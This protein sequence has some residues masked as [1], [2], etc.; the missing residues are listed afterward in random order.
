MTILFLDRSKGWNHKSWHTDEP[1][2]LSNAREPHDYRTCL[3]IE[4]LLRVFGALEP[5]I[6][7][8]ALTLRL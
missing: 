8:S 6:T 1:N 4:S 7:H 2:F 3:L 5:L